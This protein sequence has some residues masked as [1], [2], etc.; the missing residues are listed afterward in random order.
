[1]LAIA[2]HGTLVCAARVLAVPQPTLTRSLAAL[3]EKLG[4]KLFDRRRQGVIPTNQGRA[5][6]IEASEIVD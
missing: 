2:E 6:L 3:E 4:A 5:V 1:V